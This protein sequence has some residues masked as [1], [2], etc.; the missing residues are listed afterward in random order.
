[1]SDGD[2]SLKCAQLTRAGKVPRIV[3]IV[4]LLPSLSSARLVRDLLPALG[5]SETDIAALDWDGQSS[6]VTPAPR[7]KSAI[8]F[9]IVPALQLFSTL[10]VA[11]VSDIVIILLSS[12]NEVQLE[13]EAI[14]RCLQGQAG[15]V[16]TLACVQVC[17]TSYNGV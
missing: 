3:S 5:L 13:G 7:F 17:H 6:F 4:P 9:N 8:H 11:L 2:T 10:D 1:M 16:T 12:V 15:A 14:L